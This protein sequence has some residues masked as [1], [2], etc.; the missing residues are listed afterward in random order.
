MLGTWYTPGL[1]A[2]GFENNSSD[3]IVAVSWQIYDNYP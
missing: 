1:G 2:C 3:L